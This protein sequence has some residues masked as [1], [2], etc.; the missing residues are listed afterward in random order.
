MNARNFSEQPGFGPYIY[1]DRD[2]EEAWTS[3]FPTAV[4]GINDEL[5]GVGQVIGAI[6]DEDWDDMPVIQLDD[7]KSPTG[8]VE[9]LGVECWWT[10][11]LEDEL[12]DVIASK[13]A[14]RTI[15]EASVYVQMLE[16]DNN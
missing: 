6:T 10:P 8:K 5:L 15:M 1:T 13:A 2:L 4:I 12:V 14:G 9:I 11:G 3:P 7:P 16:A